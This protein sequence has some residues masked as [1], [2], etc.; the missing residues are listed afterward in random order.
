MG[1]KRFITVVVAAFAAFSLLAVSGTA[2]AANPTT[3]NFQGKVVNADGTNVTDGNYTFSFKLYTAGSGGSAIW[4]GTQSSVAV[5]SGVFQVNLGSVCP[6]FTANA[7]NNNTPIDFN[8]NP[9]LYLGITFNNDAAGEMSPR[10]QLQSVA[11]AFNAD[12]VGGMGV[13]Q[14]VQLSPGSAQSGSLNVTGS[15][16][17]GSGVVVSGASSFDTSIA[18]GSTTTAASLLMKDGTSNSRSVTLNVPALTASYTLTLPASAPAISKCLATDSVTATQ[19]VFNTCGDAILSG[20]QTFTGTDT[21]TGSGNGTS[22][23]GVLFKNATDSATALNVQNA[24]GSNFLNVDTLNGA[25]LV[26][27]ANLL[28]NGIAAPT[29]V[30]TGVNAA[31]GANTGGTLSGSSGTTYYYRVSSLNGTTESA[32]ATEISLA[33]SSF[34]PIAAPTTAPTAAQSNGGGITGTYCYKYTYVTANGET[35]ASTASNC[36]VVANKPVAVSSIST[37]ASSAVT[38]RKVYRTT[39]GG[40]TYQLLTTIN[41]NTTTTFSD[42]TLDASLGA[43]E[44]GSNTARTNTNNATISWTAVS[45]ATSYRIYRGT[46]AGN[47]TAYQT[48]TASPFTDTGAAGTAGTPTNVVSSLKLGINTLSPNAALDVNGSAIVSGSLTSGALTLSSGATITGSVSMAFTGTQNLALTSDLAGNVRGISFVGTPSSTAGTVFGTFIQQA[49]SAN[50][51]GIDDGLMIDNADTDLALTNAI[52]ITNSGGGGYTS[53]LNAPNFKIAGTGEIWGKGFDYFDPS[54]LTG[55]STSVGSGGATGSNFGGVFSSGAFIETTDY[56]GQDFV[57]SKAAATAN[58]T[59][60]GDDGKWYFNNAAGT[61]VSATGVSTTGGYTRLTMGT[62]TARGGLLTEGATAGTLDAPL[63]AANLPVVQMKVRPSTLVATD[64]LVW[65]MMDT[66][67]APTVNDTLP[68][69]GIF[70]WTNNTTGTTGWTGVVKN[71]ATSKTVT[72]PGNVTANA[73]ATGRIV[74]VNTTTVRF[75]MD[76]NAS[77]GVNLVDCGT[78]TTDATLTALPAGNLAMGMYDVHTST[79]ST[80]FDLDYA[81][82][83]QDDAPVAD[84][85]AAATSAIYETQADIM[86]TEDSET[87]SPDASLDTIAAAGTSSVPAVTDTELLTNA[88]QTSVKTGA[89]NDTTTV[90]TSDASFVIGTD[91]SANYAGTLNVAS[92]KVTG[93]L[94]V[95]GDARF[96]GLTTFEKLATFLGKVVFKQDTEFDGHVTV[97]KDS[98]GYAV[99]KAGESKVHVTFKQAYDNPPVVNASAYGG[100]FAVSSVDNVDAAGFDIVLQAPATSDMKFS[101][102]ATGV[103]DPQTAH[104]PDA[105]SAV[106]A[107]AA[108]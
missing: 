10:V 80:T 79:T 19:L 75:F 34:V 41:D 60:F 20:N 46:S 65:G 91:G 102:T 28:L 52:S 3:M 54:L 32:A 50:T 2:S 94:T 107:T 71:G 58:N 66:A 74:V 81:R 9:N 70:F 18:L 56:Y 6:F 92:A 95:G 11:F 42:T 37:S 59:A 87:Q 35:T 101:W 96:I 89:A 105:A 104:S 73:F 67:A 88:N 30:P 78:I 33:G 82:F 23:Y 29:N 103:I 25:V 90:Q 27:N 15:G 53:Y 68:T 77:N 93:G 48:I 49:N 86:T 45:G 47:E 51:N 26:S 36:V 17:F 83:W 108:E 69:N 13:S 85:T 64:D 57:G 43:T 4:T 76:V 14:L 16:T 5:T 40:S 106:T 98:A 99:F 55:V 24:A 62:T 1:K 72:C 100:K 38:S 7:C 12:K 84:S 8:A 21:F 63:F 44:P 61:T 97:S 39:N 22:T 31:A